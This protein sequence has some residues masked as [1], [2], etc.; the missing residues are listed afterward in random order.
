MK[1]APL[2]EHLNADVK[3]LRCGAF[4]IPDNVVCGACGANLPLVY[5]PDGKP[6]QVL[7]DGF[8]YS[9]MVGRPRGGGFLAD[10]RGRAAR[11]MWLLRFV[12]LLMVLLAAVWI[13]SRK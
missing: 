11:G 10:P 13:L 2:P 12:I 4:N 3:C 7:D 5:G 1:V 9:T 8:R 6:R